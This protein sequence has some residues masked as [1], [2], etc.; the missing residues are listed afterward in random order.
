MEIRKKSN[1]LCKKGSRKNQCN[2]NEK[3]AQSHHKFHNGF[4]EVFGV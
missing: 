3:T 2:Q 1:Q 4:V